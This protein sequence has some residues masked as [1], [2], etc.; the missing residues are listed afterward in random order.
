MPVSVRPGTRVCYK[1]TQRDEAER[2]REEMIRALELPPL[3]NAR[4]IQAAL[5]KIAQALIDCRIDEGC[6]GYLLQQV[7]TAMVRRQGLPA[8]LRTKKRAVRMSGTS[9]VETALLDGQTGIG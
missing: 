8:G 9:N 5:G 1:H 3:S 2:R 4:S 7:E 6:A